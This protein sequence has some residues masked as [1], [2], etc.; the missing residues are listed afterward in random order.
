M[1]IDKNYFYWGVM[2]VIAAIMIGYEPGI[3]GG[4]LT[5]GL[6]ALSLSMLLVLNNKP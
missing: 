5:V 4:I 6:L 1:M 2:A 3:V